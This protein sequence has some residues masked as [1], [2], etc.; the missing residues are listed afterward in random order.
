M[1]FAQERDVSLHP[2][3]FG[4]ALSRCLLESVFWSEAVGLQDESTRN[5]PLSICGLVIKFLIVA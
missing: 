3:R 2:A 1:P 5:L 4:F